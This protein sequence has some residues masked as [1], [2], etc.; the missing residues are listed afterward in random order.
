M[1]LIHGRLNGVRTPIAQALCRPLGSRFCGKN[2]VSVG[3][4][5]SRTSTKL[6]YEPRVAHC[7]T[8]IMY[9][10]LNYS[11]YSKLDRLQLVPSEIAFCSQNLEPRPPLQ[12]V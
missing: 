10:P 8:V 1:K 5:R 2:G 9:A 7:S 12:A 4:S 11:K 3:A 6:Q